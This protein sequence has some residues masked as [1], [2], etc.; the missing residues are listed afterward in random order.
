MRLFVVFLCKGPPQAS[1][2]VTYPDC[3]RHGDI[4]IRNPNDIS[5]IPDG[6]IFILKNSSNLRPITHPKVY[7]NFA[8][9]KHWKSKNIGIFYPYFSYS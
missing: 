9:K 1:K 4:M 2:K 5:A 7:H 6:E 8:R 3:H